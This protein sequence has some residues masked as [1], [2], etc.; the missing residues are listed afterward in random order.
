MPNVRWKQAGSTGPACALLVDYLCIIRVSRGI[1]PYPRCFVT[2]TVTAI[3]RGV[4]AVNNDQ[5][6]AES[7]RFRAR[8]ILGPEYHWICSHFHRARVMSAAQ[9]HRCNKVGMALRAG[10]MI[11]GE[12]LPDLEIFLQGQT[13][14]D[15]LGEP[16]LPYCND[17]AARRVP[18]KGVLRSTA[19]AFEPLEDAGANVTH[20]S[21]HSAGNPEK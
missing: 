7:P 12:T 10:P 19:G 6:R 13:I 3:K 9:R 1:L 20:H 4:E 18:C 8:Y 15:R 5:H 16:S 21:Q 11:S 2:Q 14:R 17:A